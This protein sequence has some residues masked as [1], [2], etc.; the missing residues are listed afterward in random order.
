MSAFRPLFSTKDLYKVAVS[1]LK[2]YST[3]P[4]VR[5]QLPDST[6]TGRN[7]SSKEYINF[8]ITKYE[9][10]KN[11]KKSSFGLSQK[12]GVLGCNCGFQGMTVSL[13]QEK[14]QVS[15][16]E[17]CQIIQR[18]SYSGIAVLLAP[19]QYRSH[20][21]QHILEFSSEKNLEKKVCLSQKV[22][23]ELQWQIINLKLTDGNFLVT[24]KLQMKIASNVP[25]KG[26]GNFCQ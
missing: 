21:R 13:P 2:Q 26:L 6:F 18:L 9:C 24:A 17:I 11:V 8:S 23:E 16:T 5:R 20:S 12:V 14:D 7:D 4:I 25:R 3:N 15:V 19:S 22:R 10:Q 1:I